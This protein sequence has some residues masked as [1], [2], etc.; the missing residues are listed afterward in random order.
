MKSRLAV[1]ITGRILLTNQKPAP[2]LG[3]F[4]RFEVMVVVATG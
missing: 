4:D 1:A 2:E 3:F